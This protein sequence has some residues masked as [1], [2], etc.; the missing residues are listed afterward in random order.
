MAYAY[1][2]YSAG[3]SQTDYTIAWPYIKEAHVKVYVNFVD[4]S[5]TFHN[6]TTARLASAPASGTRVEVRRVTPPS[7][8]LVDYADGSTLTAS[9]LDT[10]NLQHLY[11]AQELDDALKQGISISATTG[12]PTLSNQRLTEVADPTAAQDAAT[13]N[14]VDTQDA[15]KQPLDAELTELATMASTTAGALADL[16]QAEVQILDGATLSTDELNFVDGVTSA[17]QTQLDAKQP[18]DADLTTLSGCQTGA[19]TKIALLTSGEIAI[20]DDATVTTTELNTLDGITS[21][22][23]ELNKLDGVTAT[24]ANLN[25]VSGMT[26]ATTL[27]S[28]SDTEFPTSKAVNDRILTVT[29][30][31][32]GFVA[33]SNETSFP[34]SNPDPSD[35][36]G[37][38]ISI[39]DAGGVVVNGSGV[40]TIANGA[41]SGNTVTISGF[42]SSLYSKTLA[43][44]V[45]LQVQTTTTLHTYTY[46]KLLAKETDVEQLSD[47]INDFNNRYRTGG[48]NPD[49]DNDAGD[50]FF[51]T[52]TDKMYVRNAANNSWDEVQSI[53]EFFINTLSSV[54]SNSDSPPGGSA[55]FNGTARKFTLSNPPSVA[56]QLVVSING[57]IQKPNA[58]SAFPSEGF[59]LSGSTLQLAAAPA[60]D[61]PFFIITIGSTVN[62]GTPS[63]NTVDYAKLNVSNTGSVGQVLSKSSG[64]EGLTWIDSAPEGTA[65]KSTGITG[66]KKYLRADGDNTC[67]WQVAS[68]PEVYGFNA[69]NGNLIVTTTNGGADNISASDYAAF[70]DQFF[71]ATGFSFSI[72]ASGNLIAT[73]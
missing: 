70:E 56:Q 2:I 50:L 14:Y 51:N 60:T 47:D 18:L 31:L 21:S 26:K 65:V 68:S 57:V 23:G 25:V 61:A 15:T 49:T 45:G 48:T 7:A 3:S 5:F 24:T 37:T 40:A 55:T 17:L 73:I 53:G 67:S 63:A 6:A 44:G 32:G 36:A 52:G 27:T 11:I 28:N 58:G 13:K 72:N 1:T 9:D 12:L 35:G 59:S 64:T 41:G 33:I 22:T 43:T 29:N 20:L 30:A 8:V 34:T 16:T 54:G 19:A 38:V 66:T 39:A 69:S 62:I 42:P 46:H 10:S 4:T 71:A